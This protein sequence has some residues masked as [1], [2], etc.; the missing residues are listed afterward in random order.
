[1]RN[2]EALSKGRLERYEADVHRACRRIFGDDVYVGLTIDRSLGWILRDVCHH[3]V[4]FTKSPSIVPRMIFN[5]A[6]RTLHLAA[7]TYQMLS[8]NDRY[9]RELMESFSPYTEHGFLKSRSKTRNGFV[10]MM[11]LTMPNRFKDAMIAIDGPFDIE[12]P[13]EQLS[14]SHMVKNCF[15]GVSTFI[16]TPDTLTEACQKA[17][18]YFRNERTAFI[19]KYGKKVVNLTPRTVPKDPKIRRKHGYSCAC[20]AIAVDESKFGGDGADMEVIGCQ[21][22]PRRPPKRMTPEELEKTFGETEEPDDKIVV[23]YDN[24]FQM[25]PEGHP[26]DPDL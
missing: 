6:C 1:M 25:K 7:E 12:H 3:W 17:A 13:F 9:K 22:A 19:A 15:D 18:E 23:D 5:D 8:E 20:E 4:P 24:K 21:K 14:F 2:K 16:I 10:T 26:Q 11:F